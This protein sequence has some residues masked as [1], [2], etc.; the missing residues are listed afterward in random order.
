MTISDLT[1]FAEKKYNIIE[2]FKWSDFPGFSV[3]CHPET[4]KWVALL[5]R[6]WNG[7]I[8]EEIECCDI[9]CSGD[10]PSRSYISSP[11]RMHSGKWTGILFNNDTE[12]E[13]VFALFD[14]AVKQ[15]SPSGFKI[16]LAS[17]LPQKNSVYRD[18]EIPF[19]NSSYKPK[20]D[21]APERIREMKHLYEYGRESFAARAKNFYTQAMFMSDYEDDFPWSGDFL[22]YFP[23]YHE[24]TTN[25]L[26]GYFTWRTQIRKG[27]FQHIPTSAAYI[28]IYELL[29]G[30]GVD[31][32]E[33]S[34]EK[35]KSFESGYIDSGLGDIKM[36]NNLQRW[37]FEYAV[38]NN[39]PQEITL[40]LSEPEAVKRENALSVLKKPDNYR[41]EDVYD[42]L[43]FLGGRK[44]GDSPVIKTYPDRG[45]MMFAQAWKSALSYKK[46]EKALFQQCF[47]KKTT[48]RWYPLANAVYYETRS[49]NCDYILNDC[50]YYRCKNGIWTVTSY[51]K[52]YFDR[53]LLKGFLHEADALF[54]RYLK[55][56][57]Y[58]KENPSAEWA[59]PFINA[60]IQCDKKSIEEAKKTKITISIADLEKIRTEAE[61][62]RNSLIVEE[63]NEDFIDEQKEEISDLQNSVL[64]DNL[65]LKI[66]NA[67]VS[68]KD[69]SDILESSHIMPSLAADHINEALYD[70]I[71]DTVV[72]CENNKLAIVED[73]IE[74]I[75][76][77][78]GGNK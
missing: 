28:Y 3:L 6:Q 27:V 40:D 51:E 62:T 69:A 22:C 13:V 8:G 19:S 18:T 23:T 76:H 61:D 48:R 32:P 34:I 45:K 70:E 15:G 2:Q 7:D 30:A 53:E 21:Q 9:K 47:G 64:L 33:E 11:L 56:G 46:E 78:I 43:V 74:D 25:Q 38:I 5:M 12:P 73:Y 63:D 36:R 26:R 77:L 29:N 41:Y 17:N 55:T 44:T 35:L 75:E 1:A 71:G 67:L 60:A 49:R 52:Q 4:G 59:I 66:L 58:L 72:L 24:L 68:G 10:I 14:K 57:K 42:A 54:R 39:L 31:S 20:S 50:R 65:H 16:T 37:M